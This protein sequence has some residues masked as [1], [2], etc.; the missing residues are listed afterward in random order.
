[1]IISEQGIEANRSGRSPDFAVRFDHHN[2]CSYR[3]QRQI[4]LVDWVM[5][6]ILDVASLADHVRFYRWLNWFEGSFM[7]ILYQFGAE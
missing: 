2:G 3:H 4:W 5:N 7:K 6:F 1:M